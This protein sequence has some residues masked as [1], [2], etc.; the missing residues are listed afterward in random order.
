MRGDPSRPNALGTRNAEMT[1]GGVRLAR[2]IGNKPVAP[3]TNAPQ[4]P[5]RTRELLLAEIEAPAKRIEKPLANQ[6]ARRSERRRG[7]TLR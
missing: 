1:A 6:T 2:T 5:W 4:T 3:R 7:L